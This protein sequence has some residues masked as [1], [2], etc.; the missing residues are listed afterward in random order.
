MRRWIGLPLVL[1]GIALALAGLAAAL[2]LFLALRQPWLGISLAPPPQ[3]VPGLAVAALHPGGPGASAG[4][5]VGQIL[6]TIAR[7]PLERQDILEEP[8][9]LPSFA[10]LD[11]F[12]AR[13]QA[14]SQGLAAPGA[15][16]ILSAEGQELDL[17]QLGPRPIS[18]LPATFW[19]QLGTGL[20]GFL[21]GAWVLSLHRDGPAEGFLCLAGIGLLLSALA[22]AV[23]SSRELALPEGPFRLLTAINHLGALVF[24][25]GM[26]GLFL[27]YPVR[28]VRRGWLVLPILLP[29][30]WW[31]ANQLGLLPSP[32]I[33]FQLPVVLAMAGIVLL[34]GVQ[35]WRTRGDP[36][37]RAA[38][39]WIGLSVLVGAGAFVVTII[40]PELMGYEAVLLQG[41]AFLF[42]L[43]IYGGIALGVARFRLFELQ[44]WAFRILFYMG[45]MILLVLLDV[46]LMAGIPL[47]RAPSLGLSLLLV[48]LIY[49]PLRDGLSRWLFGG[50]RRPGKDLYRALTDVALTPSGPVRLERWC[51]VLREAFDPLEIIPASTDPRL[52]ALVDD[53][54]VLELPGVDTLPPLRLVWAKA[55]RALF[56]RQDLVHATELIA[57]LR[58]AAESR[59]AYESGVSEERARIARDMHDNIGVQLIGALHSPS[60]QRKDALIREALSDLREIISNADRP[61][62]EVGELLSDLRASLSEHLAA[63]GMRLDWDLHHEGGGSLSPRL[64]HGLR[65]VLREAIGNAIRHSG[66]SRVWVRVM[67]ASD[68]LHLT[69]ED[70]GRGLAEDGA[71]GLGDGAGEPGG[72]HGLANMRARV[73]GLGGLLFIGARPGGG[74]RLAGE[75][76]LNKE[77]IVR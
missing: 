8:D 44:D 40:L 52:P 12:F 5:S 74:L 25:M 49:L 33:G 6:V 19:G 77:G 14:L 26:L 2:V 28:L 41:V 37:A 45:G 71:R 51:R 68:L 43:P 20:A 67:L 47:D 17:P 35:I 3:G 69:V 50:E 64:A 46:A 72:G 61:D 56:H 76:P 29:G 65:S 55:G 63:A 21:F 34:I 24:G 23:Y 54:A 38:L 66:A 75:I 57:M 48:A 30:L 59:R 39:R 11:R 73:R 62:L 18:D 58:G 16:Q 36:R 10:A 53:G 1:P 32:G 15:L 7:V 13:Q 9:M 22:A 70:N 4:L 42:F 31:L 27:V 60:P